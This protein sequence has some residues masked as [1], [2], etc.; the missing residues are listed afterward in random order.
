MSSSILLQ[1]S[2]AVLDQV[3]VT[4]LKLPLRVPYKLAFG[5][6]VA[7]DTLLAQCTVAGRQGFGEAT[8]LT[9]YTTETIEQAWSLGSAMADKLRGVDLGTAGN[10]LQQAKRKAPFTVAM[11]KTALEM[12][13]GHP[14]LE[15]ENAAS[16]PL[17]FGL[18]PTEPAAIDKELDIAF[19]Q[20]YQTVKVKVGFNL[21][22]DLQRVRHIQ[23]SSG[24]RLSLRIDGNQGYNVA[25]AKHFAS[26]IS[27]AHIEL[28]EQPCHMDDWSALAQ[29]IK[30]SNVPVMLDESIYTFEDIDRAAD[31]G[32]RFVKLKLMKTGSLDELEEGLR[33]IGKLGMTA[34]LGNGVASDPGCW[35]EACVARDLVSN[36]GE[37]NGFLRV[38]ESII[39]NPMKVEAGA[40]KLP[41]GYKPELDH[42]KIDRFAI[43]DTCA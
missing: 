19:Q 6:L 40:I 9:G 22:A 28:L 20:G 42:Q 30:V 2:G 39:A 12:A 24:G 34:V 36:A 32:A 29:V 4:R 10:L 13:L 38:S 37:M 21:A 17:L 18:N 15:S 23:Q 33:R 8:I 26:T 31:I 14:V 5:N 25:D 7:F 27:P 1:N 43:D 35:M 11:F 3:R 41:A 16:I